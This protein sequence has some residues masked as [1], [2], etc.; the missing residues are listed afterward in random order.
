MHKIL[1]TSASYTYLNETE[2]Q[3]KWFHF[4]D[5]LTC[6]IIIFN[7]LYQRKLIRSKNLV[8]VN[9]W[10]GNC[11]ILLSTTNIR[12]INGHWLPLP[13]KLNK[14]KKHNFF[15]NSQNT[16]KVHAYYSNARCNYDNMRT[17]SEEIETVWKLTL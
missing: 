13:T 16:F 2:G 4:K 3:W 14:K 5:G 10:S 9:I 12:T 8:T 1:S 15:Q 6:N 7:K 11:T 17:P